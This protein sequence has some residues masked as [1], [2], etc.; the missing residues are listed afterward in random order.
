MT[1]ISAQVALY[2]LGQADIGAVIE[3]FL[4]ALGGWGVEYRIGSMSTVVWGERDKLFAALEEAFEVVSQEQSVVMNV[5]FSNACP[6]PDSEER[7]NG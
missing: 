5:T 6:L 1:M 2:P 3:A 7:A 4:D